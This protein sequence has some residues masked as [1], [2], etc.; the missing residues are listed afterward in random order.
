MKKKAIANIVLSD[1]GGNTINYTL[2]DDYGCQLMNYVCPGNVVG[3]NI[4]ITTHV[5]CK[6]NSGIF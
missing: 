2:W 6:P 5:L 1:A 3:P 4:L